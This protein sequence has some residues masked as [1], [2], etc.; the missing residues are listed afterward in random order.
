MSKLMNVVSLVLILLTALVLWQLNTQTHLCSDDYL[1]SFKFDPG[2]A[3]GDSTSPS[4]QRITGIEDYYNSLSALYNTLTGRIVAHGILQ[5]MLMLPAWI[6]D[7]LNTMVFLA[8]SYIY[9][10]W[11]AGR[12]HKARIPVWLLSTMLFYLSIPVSQRNV[13]FPAFSCNYIWT[14]LIVFMFLIPVRWLIQED[15]RQE[16]GWAFA[17]LMFFLGLIA[18]DTNEPL[19]PGVLLAMGAYAGYCLIKKPRQLPRWY[20]WAMLGLLLGFVFLFLAPGNS[21]RSSYETAKTGV[22]AIGFSL[23]N[24]SFIAYDL[25]RAIPLL[26]MGILGVLGINRDLIK[27]NWQALLFVLIALSGTLFALLI[28]P[29]YSSR[30]SILLLGLLLVICLR[31]FM[32]RWGHSYKALAVCILLVSVMFGFRL[33]KDHYWVNGADQEYQLFRE[34]IDACPSDSCLVN[35]RAY[36][37]ALTAENWAK[38]VATY[39]H[40]RHLWIKDPYATQTR[41]TWKA[42]RYARA[43]T[44]GDDGME[45][46][47]L[48]YVN[49]DAYSRTLYVSLKSARGRAAVDSLGLALKT[50]DLPDLVEAVALSLPTKLLY[51]LLPSVIIYR[52]EPGYVNNNEAVYSISMPIV[53][54]REDILCID[55]KKKGSTI[56]SF[57]VYEVE[58][59]F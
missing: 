7:L 29:I 42:A 9:S 36:H 13:Y 28:P 34:Q 16:R 57:Y 38:P 33:M 49:H 52:Y 11:V 47:G 8:L 35:P 43:Q 45:M 31:L 37:D 30:M 48:Y 1:Y 55:I 51:Y 5:F 17:V 14:Q 40:K 3:S 12:K 41:K 39:Y 21:G 53:N 6:F 22:R 10:T 19:V 18:G 26:I 44:M 54:G 32:L 23:N 2:F 56:Q 4:Y 46:A 15:H 24:L 25:I 50:A 20:Y 27:Q 58:F 59:P